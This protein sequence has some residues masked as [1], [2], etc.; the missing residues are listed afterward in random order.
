MNMKA[1]MM[2]EY[3]SFFAYCVHMFTS[4]EIIDYPLV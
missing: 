3:E 2:N 4:I 1:T